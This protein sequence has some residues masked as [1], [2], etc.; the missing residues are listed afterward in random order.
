MLK[1]VALLSLAFAPLAI[2]QTPSA[3]PGVRIPEIAGGFPLPQ[4]LEGVPA[5]HAQSLRL[6][7]I[8]APSGPRVKLFNGK[9]LN[10][11]TPWLGYA[12]GSMFP[13]SADDKPLGETGVGDI[14]SVVSEEG[15]P[16]IYISG[17]V[18]GSLNTTQEYGNYHLSLRYKFRKQWGTEPPNTGVL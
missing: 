2:A 4:H 9:D 16:A 13:A 3:P 12:N 1:I 14:F 11:F 15:A 10:N 7:K 6:A 18:W 17:K 5:F 8:P